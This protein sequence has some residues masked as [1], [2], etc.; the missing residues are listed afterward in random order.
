M[1]SYS[2]PRKAAAKLQIILLL[3]I[4]YLSFFHLYNENIFFYATIFISYPTFILFRLLVFQTYIIFIIC[5]Y[6]LKLHDDNYSKM[7]VFISF[8][9]FCIP[10]SI[11]DLVYSVAL[12]T[13]FINI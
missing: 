1:L 8:I 5:Y 12:K 2:F 13:G 7:K 4:N 10:I 3:A 11:S 6:S 9:M